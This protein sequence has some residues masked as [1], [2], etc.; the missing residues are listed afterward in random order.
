M[1]EIYGNIFDEGAEKHRLSMHGMK[2]RKIYA[3]LINFNK[4]SHI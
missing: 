2:C 3:E 4:N 1:I